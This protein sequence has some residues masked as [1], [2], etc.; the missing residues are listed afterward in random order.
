MVG[1]EVVDGEPDAPRVQAAEHDQARVGV[2]HGFAFGDLEDPGTRRC[3]GGAQLGVDA[4]DQGVVG[5]VGGVTFTE[6]SRSWPASAQ[7]A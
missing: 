7:P 3:L 2:A 5:D 1:A 6:T 4:L